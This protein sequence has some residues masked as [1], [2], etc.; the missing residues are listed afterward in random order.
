M[1]FSST[2]WSGWFAEIG[3]PVNAS[4]S[5][6]VVSQC[7]PLHSPVDY[8]CQ[9]KAFDMVRYMFMISRARM[10]GEILFSREHSPPQHIDGSEYVILIKIRLLL[11]ILDIIFHFNYLLTVFCYILFRFFFLFFYVKSKYFF[12]WNENI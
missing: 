11:F 3:R 12:L 7:A 9:F 6:S 5:I 2:R 1:S 10:F 8:S 4:F